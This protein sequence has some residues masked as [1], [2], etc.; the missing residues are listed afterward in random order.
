MC[1]LYPYEH[2]VGRESKD[3]FDIHRFYRV[4][5][6]KAEQSG[7]MWCKEYHNINDNEQLVRAESQD[8]PHSNTTWKKVRWQTCGKTSCYHY[9]CR[10]HLP[11]SLSKCRMI[12]CDLEPD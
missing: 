6:S 9:I 10:A 2:L 8:A 7:Q 12:G 5:C 1:F 4:R 11:I 3:E